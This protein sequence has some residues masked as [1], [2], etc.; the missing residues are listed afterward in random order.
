MVSVYPPW[1][2]KKKKKGKFRSAPPQK[3]KKKVPYGIAPLAK[4]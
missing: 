4:L 3:E 2:K 1:K